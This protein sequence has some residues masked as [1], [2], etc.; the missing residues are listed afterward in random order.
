MTDNEKILSELKKEFYKE[1]THSYPGDSGV[2]GNDPQE[3]DCQMACYPDELW[4]WIKNKIEGFHRQPEAVKEASGVTPA[5]IKTIL[6]RHVRAKFD[7][8]NGPSI[9]EAS[10]DEAA[11]A[12]WERRAGR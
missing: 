4:Q 3:P 1:F 5:Q 12:V 2:G 7:Y 8:V 9:D 10:L 11:E 6:K